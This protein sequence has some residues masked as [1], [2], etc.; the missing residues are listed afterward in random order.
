MTRDKRR[1]RYVRLYYK[2]SFL[3]KFKN[4]RIHVFLQFLQLLLVDYFQLLLLPVLNHL[5]DSPL[6]HEFFRIVLLLLPKPALLYPPGLQSFIVHHLPRALHGQPC[7]PRVHF[8]DLALVPSR[9]LFLLSQ[10]SSH[11]QFSQSVPPLL[12]M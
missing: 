4:Y 8:F 1:K 10:L 5:C 11:T 6:L 7:L 2:N 12:Q 9:Q 3:E